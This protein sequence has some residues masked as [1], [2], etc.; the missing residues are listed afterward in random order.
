M[1]ILSFAITNPWSSAFRNI[2][3]K[4]GKTPLKHKFWE[5]ELI[6][7]DSIIGFYLNVLHRC[8]HAGVTLELSLLG[9]TFIANLY[10]NR[11]WNYET[12]TYE[13]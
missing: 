6:R 5:V 10:D 13:Q 7:S 9:Y 4:H 12:G 8:S 3:T 11:H 1:I 2:W